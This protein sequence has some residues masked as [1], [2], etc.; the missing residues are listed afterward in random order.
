VRTLLEGPVTIGYSYRQVLAIHHSGVWDEKKGKFA[1]S[2]V[3]SDLLGEKT[4]P[5]ELRK[6]ILNN[7][8]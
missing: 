7:N 5:E 8:K 2:T 3:L 6:Q 4:F 1:Y